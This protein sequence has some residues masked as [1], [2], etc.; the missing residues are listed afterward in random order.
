V[1]LA[2]VLICLRNN[3]KIGSLDVIFNSDLNLLLLIFNREADVHLITLSVK[4][5]VSLL[6]FLSISCRYLV[7]Y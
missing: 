1:V 5:L 3:L 7:K 4:D 2:V 6:K